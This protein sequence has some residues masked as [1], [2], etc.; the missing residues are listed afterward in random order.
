MNGHSAFGE[1]TKLVVSA[2]GLFV[3]LW[4][5]ITAP[6][7]AVLMILGAM[8]CLLTCGAKLCGAEIPALVLQRERKSPLRE[9]ESGH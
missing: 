3:G 6:L 1:L 5:L 9:H 2:I 7:I 8:G 4:L